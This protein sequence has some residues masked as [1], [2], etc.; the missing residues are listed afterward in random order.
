[1]TFVKRKVNYFWRAM[2]G[3]AML[4]LMGLAGCVSRGVTVQRNIVYDQRLNQ[5]LDLFSP[6]NEISKGTIIFVHGG[7][8]RAG[9]KSQYGFF[10][11]TMARKGYTTAV[12]NYRLSKTAGYHGMANDV[13]SSVKWV[14]ENIGLYHGNRDRIFLAGH[15]AGG[16][17]A[18][19]VASNTSYF[20]SLNVAPVQ[21]VLLIDAFGLDMNRYLSHHP[22]KG[23]SVYYRVFTRDSVNWKAASPASFLRDGLPPFLLLVGDKTFNIIK[24]DNFEFFYNLKEYQPEARLK[25]IPHRRHAGMVLQFRKR[26]S[27]VFEPVLEFLEGS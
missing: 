5:R 24:E 1:M 20:D 9:K 19:L 18:A 27:A 7:R 6:V 17:L 23:K 13:T 25:L 10:G 12:I 26:K 22:K 16:H 3:L 21:G 11:K 2:N 14:Q 4:L 8:W 15:S